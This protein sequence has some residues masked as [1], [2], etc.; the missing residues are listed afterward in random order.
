MFRCSRRAL[1]SIL[2]SSAMAVGTLALGLSPTICAA[3]T[4]VD[5]GPGASDGG[6]TAVYGLSSTDTGSPSQFIAGQ[7][8]IN[9]PEAITGVNGWILSQVTGTMTAAIYSDVGNAPGAPLDSASFTVSPLTCGNPVCPGWLGTSGT[10]WTLAAGTYWAVFEV[11]P[12]DSLFNVAPF[13]VLMPQLDSDSTTAL[14]RYASSEAF[15]GASPTFTASDFSS[16]GVGWGVQV[17]GS[18]VPL[19]APLW[20]LL[21]GLGWVGLV[22]R[23]RRSNVPMLTEQSASMTTR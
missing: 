5:T 13:S 23:K 4:I 18:P 20:L 21:S 16:S 7:F 1:G 9:T 17:F 8:V 3:D 22:A 19:P 2:I 14:S 6:G 10:S 15:D 12:S 11:L